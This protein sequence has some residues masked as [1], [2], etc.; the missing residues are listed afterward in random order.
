MLFIPCM[1]TVAVIRQ[2]TQSWA[3]TLLD[4]GLFLLISFAGGAAAYHIALALGI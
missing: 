4:I 1:A 3:W 2:E